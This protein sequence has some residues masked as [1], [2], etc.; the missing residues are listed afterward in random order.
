MRCATWGT[1]LKRLDASS[2]YQKSPG[3]RS[4]KVAIVVQ[5]SNITS[6]ISKNT[7]LLS[8]I[9]PFVKISSYNGVPHL[10]IRLLNHRTFHN[11]P[12]LCMNARKK[13]SC[14]WYTL[15]PKRHKVDT[16]IDAKYNFYNLTQFD[17]GLR[18]VSSDRN[19]SLATL[20]IVV[21]CGSRWELNDSFG[22]SHFLESMAFRSTKHFS[23]KRSV[24]IL[25]Q[26]AVHAGCSANREHIT[27]QVQ[28]ERMFVSKILPLLSESVMSPLF[29]PS[30]VQEKR[31]HMQQ[32]AVKFASNVD[33]QVTELLH[34]TSWPNNTL[35]NF[36]N[37]YN[38]DAIHFNSES[39]HSFRNKHFSWPRIVVSAVNVNH[40]Q[41][42][43]LVEETFFHSQ[44]APLQTPPMASP[45]YSGSL[46][47]VPSDLPMLHMA[48]TFRTL[49]G[50]RSQD[51][52]PLVVLQS[53]LGGGG[54]FSMGGPGKGMHS[55]LYNEAL[56]HDW[57]ENCVAL[58]AQYTDDGFFGIYLTG[59][60]EKMHNMMVLAAYQLGKMGHVTQEEL[61]RA[62]NSVKS[63]ILSNME[64]RNVVMEDMAHQVMIHDTVVSEDKLCQLV[65]AVSPVH[66]QNAVNRLFE[67]NQPTVVLYG[68]IK[69][70]P[71]YEKIVNLLQEYKR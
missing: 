7:T 8:S 28:L 14:A 31:K 40:K 10:S 4:A 15:L 18:V 9:N 47:C 3:N 36:L 13:L 32:E 44:D 69:E 23:F 41:L 30:E 63:M 5:Q 57:I 49:N 54:S 33:A 51:F 42:C 27:Y 19:G 55:R 20:G 43:D 12:K 39:L 11:Y 68:S 45:T 34:M 56:C 58:S 48:I 60:P 21:E 24:E 66:I 67:G 52:I 62:K 71:S 65:E 35:G 70:Y 26:Y 6:Q 2:F 46:C 59:M 61:K 22:C 50:L 16:F 17:N 1:I 53:L 29:L 64:N 37:G 38:Y 25:E